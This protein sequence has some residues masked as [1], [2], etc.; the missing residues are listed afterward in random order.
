[1]TWV[2]F[3]LNAFCTPRYQPIQNVYRLLRSSH[4]RWTQVSTDFNRP[5]FSQL[6]SEPFEMILRAQT[7]EIVTVD[8]HL[9]LS[10]RMKVQTAV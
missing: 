4:S 5:V 9:D 2:G 1:M 10:S 6:S 3:Q 8:F 7:G